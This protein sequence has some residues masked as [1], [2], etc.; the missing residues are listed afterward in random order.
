MNP[1]TQGLQDSNQTPVKGV[2]AAVSSVFPAP[3]RNWR[4]SNATQALPLAVRL[5]VRHAFRRVLILRNLIRQIDWM[6]S[7]THPGITVREAEKFLVE[8]NVLDV[9]NPHPLGF[10]N[11]AAPEYFNNRTFGGS[12]IRGYDEVVTQEASEVQTLID[13]ILTLSL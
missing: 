10:T 13:D 12:L 8:N 3:I 2:P 4:Q 1:G 7:G 11:A 5:R 6:R 9:G